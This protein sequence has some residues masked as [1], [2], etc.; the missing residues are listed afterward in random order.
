MCTMWCKCAGDPPCSYCLV[1]S[2]AGASK[3]H[4]VERAAWVTAACS[5]GGRMHACIR[6][7]EGAEA[8]CM[9]SIHLPNRR[10]AACALGCLSQAFQLLQVSCIPLRTAAAHP[11][12]FWRIPQRPT[13]AVCPIQ[14]SLVRPMQAS[15]VSPM[16]Q[17]S[18]V[19]L[20]RPGASTWGCRAVAAR[21]GQPCKLLQVGRVRIQPGEQPL[22]AA[23]VRVQGE[24]LR[25]MRGCV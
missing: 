18:R 20:L 25:A 16:M 5:H 12:C 14:A 15:L 11:P 17:A 7:E 4:H 13:Q 19:S 24:R 9:H 6:R 22:P 10:C 3:M 2:S 8:A 23:L 21:L 1:A